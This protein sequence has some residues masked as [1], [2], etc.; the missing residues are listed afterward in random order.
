MVDGLEEGRLHD[1]MVDMLLVWDSDLMEDTDLGR[2][3]RGAA[4]LAWQ[5]P[6]SMREPEV[7]ASAQRQDSLTSR[8]NSLLV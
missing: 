6:K 3:G 7:W 5:G 2:A 8:L 1:Q 4:D